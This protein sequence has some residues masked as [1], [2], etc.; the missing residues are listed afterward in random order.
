MLSFPLRI[1]GQ[2]Y[3]LAGM[4]H[5]LVSQNLNSEERIVWCGACLITYI[6]N[7]NI[8]VE[9]YECPKCKANIYN[10]WHT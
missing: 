6:Q 1:V 9:N 10:S 2:I 5:R 4:P 7:R 8:L 3:A